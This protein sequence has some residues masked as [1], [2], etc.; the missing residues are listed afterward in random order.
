MVEAHPDVKC[1]SVA[2]ILGYLDRDPDLFLTLK[3]NL[4]AILRIEPKETA[5]APS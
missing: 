2:S 5:L 3:N 4:L 1:S